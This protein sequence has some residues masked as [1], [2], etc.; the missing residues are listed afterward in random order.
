MA[1]TCAM[2]IQSASENNHN[3]FVNA[4]MATLGTDSGASVSSSCVS[5]KE[6]STNY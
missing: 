5:T 3:I 6:T 2:S 1:A 4:K